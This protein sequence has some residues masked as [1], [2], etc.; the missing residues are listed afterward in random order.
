MPETKGKQQSGV[1]GGGAASGQSGPHKGGPA[2][3]KTEESG[4]GVVQTVKETFSDW[5]SSAAEA[6]G[7]A[8]GKVRDAAVGAADKVSEWGQDLTAFI[9]RYPLPTLLAAFGVGFLVSQLV[10]RR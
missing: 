9:R 8:G 6:A 2:A 5:A 7:H 1:G 3:A 10:R 4:S